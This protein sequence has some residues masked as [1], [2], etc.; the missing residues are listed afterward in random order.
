MKKRAETFYRIIIFSIFFLLISFF[1][2]SPVSMDAFAANVRI[3]DMVVSNTRD[4]LLLFLKVEGA[5]TDRINQAV[6]NGIPTTFSFYIRVEK[7]RTLWTDALIAQISVTNSIKYDPLKK[8]FVVKRSWE[9]NRT[10]TTE[11]FDEAKKWMSE[12]QSLPFIQVNQLEKGVR[13]EVGAKA[14]LAKV[15]LPFY[16]NYILFFTS[17]W[18]FET[19]WQSVEYIR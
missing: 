11:S 19:D 1:P 2:V 18:D 3:R 10:L 14:E 12:I 15:K 17:L 8:R 4:N 16:L 7:I 5:F 9:D 6:L 13:Y